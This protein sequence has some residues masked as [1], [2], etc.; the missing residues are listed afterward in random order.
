MEKD[1]EIIEETK[2]IL[3]LAKMEALYRKRKIPMYL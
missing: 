1:K 2:I 3:V